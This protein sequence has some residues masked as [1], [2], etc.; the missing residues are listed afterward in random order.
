M[1]RR[2]LAYILDAILAGV[3]VAIVAGSLF[4]GS[5]HTIST[6]GDPNYCD[7]VSSSQMCIKVNDNEVRVISRGSFIG[8]VYG[9][10]ALVWLLNMVL[11]EGLVGGTV[12]KLAC[13]IRVVKHDGSVCGMGRALLR[14]VLLIVDGFCFALV[15]IITSSTT[16]G[17]RRVGDMAAST[18]V[19][20]KSQLGHPVNVPGVT[21]PVYDAYAT[22]S[23]P[24]AYPAPT[25]GYGQVG[26]PYPSAGPS[27]APA[28]P[29]YQADTPTWDAKRNAYIQYDTARGTWLE[30]D[31]VTGE[32]KPISQ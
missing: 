28:Q 11:L 13:G 14:N 21:S 4:F 30:H 20:A 26:G 2:Y 18:L 25:G 31:T 22:G 12:G 6:G 32:W 29:E 16:K 19:V 24:G 10:A 8:G 3:I 1:G 15:G 9:T 27:P 17:H 23:Y 7:N 5:S